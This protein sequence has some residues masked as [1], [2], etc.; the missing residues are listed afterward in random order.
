M[1]SGSLWQR[2][3]ASPERDDKGNRPGGREVR[4]P[5]TWQKPEVCLCSEL[6]PH[7]SNQGTVQH[8][9]PLLV[10]ALELLAGTSGGWAF[11]LTGNMLILET[12]ALVSA[13][14]CCSGDAVWWVPD[15]NGYYL[16]RLQRPAHART[17]VS[18]G[19][20]PGPVAMARRF[21]IFLSFQDKSEILIFM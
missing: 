10:L 21:Q 17:R 18:P 4:K 9:R 12:L 15:A 7:V 8:Q 3:G 11:G 2:I 13:Q 14:S 5:D 6:D 19:S 1:L 16:G 20:A